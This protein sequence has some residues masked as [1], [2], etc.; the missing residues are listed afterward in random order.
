MVANSLIREVGTGAD[1]GNARMATRSWRINFYHER[2]EFVMSAIRALNV[3]LE[4]ETGKSIWSHGDAPIRGGM[5]CTSYL[6]DGTQQRIIDALLLAL[7]QA[8]FELSGAP[9]VANVVPY[10]RLAAAQIDDSVPVP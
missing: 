3:I 5:A 6:S 8:R 10:S 1:H 2:G 4:D 7:V 9:E